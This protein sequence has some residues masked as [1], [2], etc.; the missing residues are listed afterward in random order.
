MAV[1]A[2]AGRRRHGRVRDLAPPRLRVAAVIVALVPFVVHAWVA[3]HGYFGQDDFVIT[4]RAAHAD[5]LDFGYLFQDYNGHLVPGTFLLAWLQ[6][7]IAPLN[8]AVA[9]VP[10][11]IMHGI[12]LWLFWR[13]L[14][15][16]F[17]YHWA[18]L[19]AFAM[20]SAS[21]LILFPTLW[22]AYGMQLLPLLVTMA[23]ALLAHLRYLDTGATR[24]AV[25]ALAWTVG[26]LL[27][28]EKAALFGGILFAVTVLQGT[29]VS[30]TL[31]KHW[32]V[33]TAHG[34][35]LV[36]Y[37]ILYFGLTASQAGTEPVSADADR[38]VHA[39]RRRGHVPAGTVRRAAHR[40]RTTPSGRHHRSRS[41]SSPSPSRWRSSCSAGGPRRGCSSPATSPWTSRW[42]RSPGSRSSARSS[43]PTRV[44]SPMP[45]PSPCSARPSRCVGG[46]P[47]GG[48]R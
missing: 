34:T 40:R 46:H 35:L 5:P 14:V 2:P 1:V 13:V 42:S 16:L 27:F 7:A 30:E 41:A 6:T 31:V 17:G 37:A 21:P 39:H 18:L 20:L 10:L 45:C 3:L 8:Y 28:Y 36:C 9:T 15:R 23:A 33:W 32:R 48:R 43:A 44:T 24:H 29:A 19:P 11:I 12:A 22:W 47:T 38:R 25:H 26:G 4:Y